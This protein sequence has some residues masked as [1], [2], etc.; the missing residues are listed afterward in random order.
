MSEDTG[1]Q[2]L[3]SLGISVDSPSDDTMST[4]NTAFEDIA[5]LPVEAEVNLSS[6]PSFAVPRL[7]LTAMVEQV[8][9]VVPTKDLYPQLK[10][11]LIEVEEGCLRLTGSDSTSHVVSTTSVVRAERTGR[12]MI[13]AQRFAE[14]VRRAA[15]PEV[16]VVCDG[17]SMRISSGSAS[18]SLRV[19]SVQDY[20]PLPDIGDV[21]WFEIGRDSFIQAITGTSYA[22]SK[23]ANKDHIAQLDISAG[24]VT[25]TD[26]LRFAQ[27]RSDKL[28]VE[29]S[30]Q[31]PASG[32]ALLLKALDRNDAP[33]FRIADSQMNIVAEIGPEHAPDRIIISHLMRPFPEVARRG[34]AEPRTSNRDVLTMQVEDLVAALRRASPTVDDETSAIAIRAGL[35]EEGKVTIDTQNRYGDLSTEVVDGSFVSTGTDNVA[36]SRSVVV[37]LDHLSQ[38][39]RAIAVASAVSDSEDGAGTVLLYLG[40]PRSKSR[41]AYVL[42]SDRSGGVQAVLSQVRSNWLS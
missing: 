16:S 38:A 14:I 18:W 24:I 4:V 3:T 20:P 23:D 37:S 11:V 8:M 13:G 34:L 7:A 35:P 32:A 26:D 25:S 5:A 15:G 41:P 33:Q 36:S 21:T 40:Q 29:F 42:I 1:L 2:L 9:S 28:P 10:C 12:V 6:P 30:C 17:P 22:V 39:V 31:L 27:V 19:S